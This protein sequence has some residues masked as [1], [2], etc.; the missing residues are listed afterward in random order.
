MG[1][2]R[3][4]IE[5][6]KDR[7]V[8]TL[9]TPGLPKEALRVSLCERTLTIE[10]QVQE[11]QTSQRAYRTSTSSFKRSFRLPKAA[12]LSKVDASYDNGLL[13]VTVAKVEAAEPQTQQIQI[14]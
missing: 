10:G 13:Q 12:E 11:E 1:N 14:K 4:H 5:E 6:E 3:V 8:L 7:Y 9:A 2:P